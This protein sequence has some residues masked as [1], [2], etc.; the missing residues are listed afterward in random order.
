VSN[1]SLMRSL[2]G[3][4]TIPGLIFVPRLKG[5]SQHLTCL[6]LVLA[7][8]E[9]VEPEQERLLVELL[10]SGMRQARTASRPAHQS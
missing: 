7:M 9:R 1:T 6:G 5:L 2:S 8:G 4:L 3:D 10:E